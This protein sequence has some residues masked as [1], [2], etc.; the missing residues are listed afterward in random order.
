MC[1]CDVGIKRR[2][3]AHYLNSGALRMHGIK[4]QTPDKALNVLIHASLHF[5]D[6]RWVGEWPWYVSGES[7]FLVHHCFTAD[8]YKEYL[9][10]IKFET[11]ILLQIKYWTLRCT[12]YGLFF[13]VIELQTFKTVRF[14]L[15]H[16]Q[17][18]LYGSLLYWQI[19]VTRRILTH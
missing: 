16:P 12:V 3:A 19:S 6:I 13:C 4:T 7:L 11:L 8:Y 5:D 1:H 10:V 2:S 17:H 15:A 18:T 14:V 9:T